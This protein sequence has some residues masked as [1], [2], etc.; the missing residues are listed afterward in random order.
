[1]VAGLSSPDL[2]NKVITL[3][4][5]LAEEHKE[6]DTKKEELRRLEHK[7]DHALSALQITK[8]KVIFAGKL[9]NAPVTRHT[10]TIE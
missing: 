1:M 2:K 10:T 7:R 3:E 4:T 8:K 9:D 5:A 6:F